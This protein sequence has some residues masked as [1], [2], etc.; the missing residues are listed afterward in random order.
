MNRTSIPS[1]LGAVGGVRFSRRRLLALL[2]S[3]LA[4]A[5]HA[6]P[7]SGGAEREPIHKSSEP[8]VCIVE[9]IGPVSA[10]TTRLTFRILRA[11]DTW[12]ENTFEFSFPRSAFFPGQ[13]FMVQPAAKG[14]TLARLF[15]AAES[16]NFAAALQKKSTNKART[17]SL[18]QRLLDDF[19]TSVRLY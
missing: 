16:R 15:S 17:K 1:A 9:K 7:K 12:S 18:R 2:L 3:I 6:A 11:D 13:F 14:W 4:P 8:E 10:D 19:L 5:L